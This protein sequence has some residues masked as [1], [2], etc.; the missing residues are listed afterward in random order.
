MSHE[1]GVEIPCRACSK[2]LSLRAFLDLCASFHPLT[3]TVAFTCP[4]CGKGASARLSSR[5]VEIGYLYAAGT[6][7]FCAVQS[8][9]APE[10]LA[11]DRD[12]MLIAEVDDQT[13]QFPSR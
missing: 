2:R 12:G 9:P 6:A 8:I 11:Y 1:L 4:A 13:W 10:L 7:H 3:R 5:E